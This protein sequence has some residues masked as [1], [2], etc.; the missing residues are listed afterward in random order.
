MNSQTPQTILYL[1]FALVIKKFLEHRS[2]KTHPTYNDSGEYKNITPVKHDIFKQLT[3]D[4]V[5]FVLIGMN[6]GTVFYNKTNFIDS[7]LGASLVSV[8][9]Y[10]TYYELLEPYFVNELPKF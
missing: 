1:I 3:L 9:G 2:N 7:Q 6:N 8:A 5:A 4:M 10:L